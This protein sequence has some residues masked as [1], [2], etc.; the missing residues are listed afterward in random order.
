MAAA[1]DD[2]RDD[3][4]DHVYDSSSETA[5]SCLERPAMTDLAWDSGGA[6][7]AI[8]DGIGAGNDG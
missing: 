6:Q 7:S 4:E 5:A 1:G 3:S 8:G 2:D